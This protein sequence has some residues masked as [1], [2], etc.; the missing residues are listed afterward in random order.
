MNKISRRIHKITKQAIKNGYIEGVQ[1]KCYTY[2]DYRKVVRAMERVE[3]RK[4]VKR[5]GNKKRSLYEKIWQSAI[6]FIND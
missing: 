3:K 5:V 1:A 6:M 4:P 2:S